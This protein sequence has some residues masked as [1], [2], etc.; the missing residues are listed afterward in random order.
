MEHVVQLG[1]NIDDE[2]I[3]RA[4]VADAKSQVIGRIEKDVRAE[5]GVKGSSWTRSQFAD[6]VADA[7]I[8]RAGGDIVEQ[9]VA[10]LVDRL[11]RRKWFREAVGEDAS[12]AMASGGSDGD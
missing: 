11:P 1:I 4:I 12:R 2:A 6:E 9:T 7:I 3:R 10:A 8:E 5:L